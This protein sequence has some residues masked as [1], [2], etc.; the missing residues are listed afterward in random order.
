MRRQ[1][2][3]I[4]RRS[5]SAS[6]SAAS[7]RAPAVRASRAATL[8]RALAAI[9]AYG[10]A[11]RS[12]FGLPG[13]TLGADDARRLLRR[14]STSASPMPTRA[15]R[16]RRT[17]CSRSA[18]SAKSM[19]AT[20]LHQFAAEGRFSLT[21][22]I[23]DA[24]ARRSRCRAAT[25]SP[26][27]TCSTMSP[28]CPATRRCSPTAGCGPLTRRR[29]LALFE[30]RLRDARQARRACRRQAARRSCSRERIF[31]PARHDAA[32][33]ARSSAPTGRSTRKAMKRPT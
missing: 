18:R 30:H 17:R 9:R 25:R 20:L 21:D 19:T 7:S 29:A 27:S 5:A 11:H 13:M 8:R 10:E 22:R 6:R 12:H 28:A 16:S 33:A 14:S 1:Q 4:H 15:R 32:A 31:A 23:S 24:A 3:R 26:S 2:A